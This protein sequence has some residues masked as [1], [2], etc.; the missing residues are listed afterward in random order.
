[1]SVERVTIGS[2]N[3][4][5]INEWGKFLDEFGIKVAGLS[6]FGNVD[7]PEENWKNF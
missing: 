3:I 6:D 1:M 5:K 4:A 7:E 2:K